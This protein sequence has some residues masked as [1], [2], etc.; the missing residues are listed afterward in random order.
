MGQL[1]THQEAHRVLEGEGS[2]EGILDRK[3][4]G[5]VTRGAYTRVAL[6]VFAVLVPL[7]L[8]AGCSMPTAFE[9]ESG[10]SVGLPL[11]ITAD[12]PNGWSGHYEEW[13]DPEATENPLLSISEKGGE[14]SIR[15]YWLRTSTEIGV[16]MSALQTPPSR[17]VTHTPEVELISALLQKPVT[18]GVSEHPHDRGV[19]WV[20]LDGGAEG[21]EVILSTETHVSEG[22]LNR[23]L[24]LLAE[25]FSGRS[26]D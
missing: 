2:A 20:I 6:R 14:E 5:Q 8:S 15:V 1:L 13:P 9:V 21:L 19:T 24:V 10:D 22:S 16:A 18:V 25:I 7:V 12:I 17:S 4:K 23:H 11:G 3:T 26:G